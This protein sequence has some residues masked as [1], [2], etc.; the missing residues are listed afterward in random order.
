MSTVK[1]A[2][3]M[4]THNSAPDLP[5]CFKAILALHHRPLQVVIVDCAS[6]DR[7]REIADAF[8]DSAGDSEELKIQTLPLGQNLGFAGGMNRALATTDAPFVLSL[9][10]DARPEPDYVT[11]L[12]AVCSEVPGTGAV[13][14]RLLRPEAEG[15]RHLDACGMR[16]TSAWRHLDRG[17]GEADRG[18]FKQREEVFGATGAASLF[19]RAALRDVS[20]GNEIFDPSF[21]SFRED[22]EL[23]FRLQERGWKVVYEPRALCEHR[24]FNLPSRRRDMPAMVNYHSLKNRYL[25]RLYHQRPGNFLRTLWATLFRDLQA[26]IYVLLCERQSLPAYTWLW[27]ERHAIRQRRRWIEGR[28]TAPHETLDRWFRHQGLPL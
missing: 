20:P 21:H 22:A 6:S 26:L 12:L 10:A 25:L 1:V 27:R 7:S 13:T 2:I 14:G 16:L 28:R 5:A 4:V 24:R 9:N 18:Q 15:I 3:A 11:H 17:S 19:V 8:R 23:C